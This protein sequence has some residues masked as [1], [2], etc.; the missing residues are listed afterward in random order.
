MGLRTT[1]KHVV[2]SGTSWMQLTR[3]V[4][5]A[6]FLWNYFLF[7]A[8]LLILGHSL[9]V[10]EVSRSH[11]D[12]SHSVGLLWTSDQPDAEPSTWQHITLTKDRHTCS[13]IWTLDPSKRAA[14][15]PCLLPRNRWD[16]HEKSYPS[17][18]IIIF[19]YTFI[20]LAC[21]PPSKRQPK[22]AQTNILWRMTSLCSAPRRTP[23]TTYLV[24]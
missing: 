23:S 5:R 21:L 2:D 14:A 7:M 3:V 1:R 16:G 22:P 8:Q 18:L 17:V 20:G 15:D 13:G 9:F 10:I 11:S 4:A 19:S 6:E 24:V 12:T